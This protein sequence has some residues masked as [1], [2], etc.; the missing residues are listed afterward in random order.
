MDAINVTPDDV[1]TALHAANHLH[2]G[3]LIFNNGPVRKNGK[4]VTFTIRVRDSHADGAKVNI[5]HGLS[6]GHPSVSERRSTSACWHAHRDVLAALFLLHPDATVITA[7]ARYEGANG[8]L[9]TF[10]ATAHRNIGSQVFP[11]TMAES[12]DCHTYDLDGMLVRRLRD[13]LSNA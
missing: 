2:G 11:I 9:D 8:F 4:R 6:N 3:N 1:E 13:V 5:R 12:C 7:M 10:P